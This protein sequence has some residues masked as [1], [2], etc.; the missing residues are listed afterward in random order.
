MARII[1]TDVAFEEF[2]EAAALES[3]FVR[4]QMWHDRYEGAHPE[5]FAAFYAGQ[6]AQRRPLAMVRE[7]ARVRRQARLGAAVLT[8]AIEEIDP[9]VRAVLDVPETPAPLHILLVGAGSVNATVGRVGADVAV[10]HCL[11]W[12]G[13][14]QGSRVLTAHETAH[15]WHEITLGVPGDDSDVAW[16]A[17]SEG[18]AILASRAAVPDRPETEYFWYG[19]PGYDD[20]LAWCRQHGAVLRAGLRERLDDPGAAEAF[21]GGQPY[22]GNRRVG[23]FLAAELLVETGRSL[24]ELAHLSV[25][26]ARE[27]VRSALSEA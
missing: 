2:A 7:L 1:D 6:G 19:L 26:E 25:A 22:E 12:V 20:W 13:S 18:L 5:I 24:P 14:E 17:F 11:E 4:E 21:F 27:L 15:A 9:R 3:P 23:Y 16:T 8:A 10:F